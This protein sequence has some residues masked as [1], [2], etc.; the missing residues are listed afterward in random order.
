MMSKYSLPFNAMTDLSVDV[1]T[2]FDLDYDIIRVH[3]VLRKK[4]HSSSPKR[5]KFAEY[6]IIKAKRSG[7]KVLV[8]DSRKMGVLC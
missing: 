8:K 3:R 2:L 5:D 6:R 7:I 1:S 4:T